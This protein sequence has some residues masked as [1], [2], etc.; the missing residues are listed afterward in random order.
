MEHFQLKRAADVKQALDMAMA[1][2]TAA[3]RQARNR[4]ASWPE[5]R[6]CST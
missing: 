1:Q 6:H 5:A 2:T 3:A 4:H